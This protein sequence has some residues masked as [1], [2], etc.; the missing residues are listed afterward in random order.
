MS[1]DRPIHFEYHRWRIPRE[2]LPGKRSSDAMNIVRRFGRFIE[3]PM[4]HFQKQDLDEFQE[5]QKYLSIQQHC[6]QPRGGMC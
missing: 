3:F 6:N 5:G 2:I 1:L 4:Q